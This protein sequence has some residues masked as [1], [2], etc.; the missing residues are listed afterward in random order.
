[1]VPPAAISASL[2]AALI[3]LPRFDQFAMAGAERVERGSGARPV[4]IDMGEAAGDQEPSRPVAWRM[5]ASVAALERGHARPRS[6]PQVI[7]IVE[8]SA[9]MARGTTRSRA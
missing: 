9:M 1:M 7:A 4:R 6:D 5:A 3:R 8:V 2:A